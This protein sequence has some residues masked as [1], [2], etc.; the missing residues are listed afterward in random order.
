MKAQTNLS[1]RLQI[2][3]FQASGAEMALMMSGT[4]KV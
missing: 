2:D 4:S 3:T 1:I